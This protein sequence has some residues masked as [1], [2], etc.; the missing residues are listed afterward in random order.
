[1]IYMMRHEWNYAFAFLKVVIDWPSNGFTS[2]IQVKAYEKWV[3]VSLLYRG[4]VSALILNTT[5]TYY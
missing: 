4:K 2:F 5:Q 1:M 3:L